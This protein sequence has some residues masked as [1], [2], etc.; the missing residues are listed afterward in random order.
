MLHSN[1][2]SA[3]CEAM[4]SKKLEL[5][6]SK[7]ASSSSAGSGTVGVVKDRM[8]FQTEQIKK[9]TDSVLLHGQDRQPLLVPGSYLKMDDT[10]DFDE[11][12][13]KEPLVLGDM[14]AAQWQLRA[15]SRQE[16]HVSSC[17]I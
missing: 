4:P 7:G 5:D 13:G 12:L 6:D 15:S 10:E 14:R 2:G 11:L 8:F 9:Y 1:S 3:F 17:A 16:A